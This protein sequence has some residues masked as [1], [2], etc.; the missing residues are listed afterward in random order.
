MTTYHYAVPHI[1][2][3]YRIS[4]DQATFRLHHPEFIVDGE[5]DIRGNVPDVEPAQA[6]PNAEPT[7]APAVPKAEP[8]LGVRMA[9]L[10]TATK[11]KKKS[12]DDEWEVPP[13]GALDHDIAAMNAEFCV[14][15]V[16]GKIRIVTFRES[17]M[18]PGQVD[19]IYST[20]D[21]FRM[22]HRNRK[23]RMMVTETDE[24]GN[25]TTKQKTVSLVDYWLKNP[26]CREYKNGMAFMP[27]D[28]RRDVP[29]PDADHMVLNTW[30]PG[31]PRDAAPG[32]WSLFK[33]HIHDNLCSGN[34]D[35]ADY[36]IKWMAWIIQNRE[37]S[38]VAVVLRSSEEGTGKSFFS[39]H[40]GHLFG[41]NFMTLSNA[42][43]IIGKFNP[44]LEKLVLVGAE[45]ALFAGDRR[46]RDAMWSLITSHSISI[47]PKGYAVYQVRSHL[48]F[49]LTT[50]HKLAVPVS[51]SARRIFELE[52]GKAQMQKYEYFDAI[53]AQLKSG[54]YLAML[55]DLQHMDLSEFS[56]TRVP[57]TTSLTAS[58]ALSREGVDHLVEKACSEARV[59]CP[60]WRHANFSVCSDIGPDKGLDY[61][62]D[63]S[64]DRTLSGLRSLN[65]K[66]ILAK[67]WDCRIGN[68]ARQRDDTGRKL[69]CVQWP[70]LA[71]LRTL[72]ETRHG[73]TDWLVP[74]AADWLGG[75]EPKVQG[76]LA[77]GG[78]R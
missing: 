58:Q 50:N 76:D 1:Q 12:T 35:Y 72:F 67:E 19:P 5:P 64:R 48:N 51:A 39:E 14:M 7:I 69:S 42:D 30:H 71:T 27:T 11:P 56:V 18:Y 44:H 77:I 15:D 53:K 13:E 59:P 43:H 8:K 73:P 10:L 2:D 62:I 17:I 34:A 28:D 60:H 38:G 31:F 32:D 78:D 9:V 36:L 3:R 74:D 37:P 63:H 21:D 29:M 49:I 45:E 68:P 16:G 54:G 75:E 20:V 40:F 70:T 22:K 52:V 55:Y 41:R 66:K 47:E 26:G 4:A 23:K 57:K 24:A 6:V 25:E 65:V 61:E 33:A 46:Q